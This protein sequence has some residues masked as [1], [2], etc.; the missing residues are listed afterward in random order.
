MRLGMVMTMAKVIEFYIPNKFSKQSG[1]WVSPEQR[2]KIIPF[3][4][5]ERSQHDV[6][7]QRRLVRASKIGWFGGRVGN[8]K[9]LISSNADLL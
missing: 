9:E 5:S 6:K 4:S 7:K 1:K 2:G 8:S 3:P